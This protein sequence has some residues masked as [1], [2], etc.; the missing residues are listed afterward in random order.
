MNIEQE[1]HS[2]GDREAMLAPSQWQLGNTKGIRL[3]LNSNLEGSLAVW[4]L[5][6]C[7]Y[8]LIKYS[9]FVIYMGVLTILLTSIIEL[10]IFSF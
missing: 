2:K 9:L 3:R 10:V 6:K 5:C 8:I 4:I 7:S 1:E